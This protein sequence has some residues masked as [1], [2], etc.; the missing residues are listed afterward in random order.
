MHTY[1]SIHVH[2]QPK[3][4][5]GSRQTGS[6]SVELTRTGTYTTCIIMTTI[7]T[8]DMQG[9][10]W[11]EPEFMKVQTGLSSPPNHS[12]Q[13]TFLTKKKNNTSRAEASIHLDTVAFGTYMYLYNVMIV[14]VEY[15]L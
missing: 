2:L 13:L 5:A 15:G 10:V 8:R 4:R 6:G 9:L 1:K 14:Y 3:I 7:T 11:G 12:S